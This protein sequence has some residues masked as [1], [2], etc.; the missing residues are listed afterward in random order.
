MERCGWRTIDDS[1]DKGF[2][3]RIHD[4]YISSLSVMAVSHC[5]NP[6]YRL[7]KLTVVHGIR[8]WRQV[9]SFQT[10]PHCFLFILRLSLMNRQ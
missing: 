10:S 5:A 4:Y 2:T 1:D 3:E 7:V 8:S 6:N 9:Y